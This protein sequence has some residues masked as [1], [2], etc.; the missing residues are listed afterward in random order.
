MR[1]VFLIVAVLFFSCY[2]YGA[3]KDMQNEKV[4]TKQYNQ[5]YSVKNPE[6]VA[7]INNYYDCKASSESAIEGCEIHAA[8]SR[9][10]TIAI[11]E[12]LTGLKQ[13][14]DKKKD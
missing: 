8:K 6:K 10:D 5:N 1:Y 14:I 13:Y 12:Y 7:V 2:W 9:F 4:W 11:N 3:V